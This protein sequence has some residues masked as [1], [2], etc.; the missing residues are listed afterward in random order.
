MIRRIHLFSLFLIFL[1]ATKSSYAQQ[2]NTSTNQ[3]NSTTN[4]IS[5]DY[6]DRITRAVNLNKSELDNINGS[7]Y[8]DESFKGVKFKRFGNKVF[9]GRYNAFQGEM[10]VI[11]DKD[12][13]ALNVSE[14]FELTF[15]DNRVYKTTN[16]T[17]KE[18]ILKRGFLIVLFESDSM[19]ILKQEVIKLHEETAAT[20]GYGNG[21][22]AEFKKAN[23]NY[24]YSIDGKV[25]ILPQKRKDFLT[26][27]PEHSSK[28]KAFIKENKINLKE[29]E[30]LITLFKY[31]ETL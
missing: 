17:N 26:L 22:P 8:M 18:G 28:L 4:N 25:S 29:D 31:L 15:L 20:N 19:A 12:T 11:F 24:F 13:I 9:S 5:Q 14:E 27:F 2:Q 7:Q 16:Y 30:D 6:M 21:K 1:G 3:I 10:E 23:S